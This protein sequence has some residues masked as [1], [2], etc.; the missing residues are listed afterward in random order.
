MRWACV[1]LPHLAI[2][3][4]LRRRAAPDAPL[5]LLSGPAHRRVIHAVSPAAEERGLRAGLT[6]GGAQAITT[7]FVAVDLDAA[8]VER[9]RAWLA[10]WAYR[11]TSQVS[12]DYPECLVLEIG[13]SRTLFG[14]W[15]AMHARL[16]AELTALGIR[17]RLAAAPYPLVARLL[18]GLQDGV[19]VDE[20]TALPTVAAL[21]IACAGL[22]DEVA[23][24][25]ERMGL[26]RLSEVFALPR[27]ALARRFPQSTLH[28]L[29]AVRGRRMAPL[30]WYAPPDVFEA[31]IEFDHDV[32]STQALL[33]PLRRLTA[34]LSA[35]LAARDGGV[36]RF[37]LQLQ[38]DGL[39][40][41][42]VVVGLLAPEREAAS[43]FDLAR[44]RLEQVRVPA[45]VRGLRLVARE[46]PPFIPV[47]RD[48]FEARVQQTTSWEQLRERLR[49]RLGDDAVHTLTI[50]P[51]HRPERVNVPSVTAKDDTVPALPRPGWLLPRPI[52]LRDHGLRVIAG[53]E[54]I[55]SGWWDGGEVRRDYYV[56]ETSQ[57]QRAWAFCAAGERGPFMLAG[58]FA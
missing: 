21:P 38:H 57:G 1:Y 27:D 42:Q 56:V 17:H 3:A 41:S 51:D 2:D 22:A 8:A 53:P 37:T 25:F 36:Q 20:A 54:R 45:P 30:T 40:E 28:Y 49:A 58:Y 4:A 7:D 15:P 33:F 32:E 5:V 14:D 52:P 11:Y 44:G 47:H 9:C 6:L 13:E 34:D 31:G 50:R 26:R 18:A 23:T 48:L 29:D 24:A 19:G 39:P 43:L 35:F 55:E 12:L 16:T 10:G 46:L